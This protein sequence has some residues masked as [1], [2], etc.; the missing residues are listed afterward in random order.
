MNCHHK[1][2]ITSIQWDIYVRE[3]VFEDNE[4]NR[5]DLTGSIIQFSVKKE[6]SDTTYLINEILNITNATNGEAEIRIALDLEP[7]TYVYDFEWT[8]SRG[9]K[10]TLEIGN[11]IITQWV[12]H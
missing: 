5:I 12:T 4:K 1:Q 6:H 7:N 9:E 3:F 11:L 8:D 2:K 10:R